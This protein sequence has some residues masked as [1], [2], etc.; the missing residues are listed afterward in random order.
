MKFNGICLKVDEIT[1]THGKI[2]KIYVVYKT[3]KIINISTYLPLENCL[4]GAVSPTKSTDIDRH[5]YSGYGIG[6]D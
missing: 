2:V 4:L 1:C 6:F 3:S 5:K